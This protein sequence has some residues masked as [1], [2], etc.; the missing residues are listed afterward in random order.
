MNTVAGWTFSLAKVEAQ[1]CSGTIDHHGRVRVG[2]Q[3]YR[4]EAGQ[5]RI[6][7]RHHF[8]TIERGR[9]ETSNP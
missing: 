6:V 8:I 3:S 4:G 2:R 1:A 7:I 5:F 9:P